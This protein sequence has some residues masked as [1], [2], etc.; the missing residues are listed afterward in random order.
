MENNYVEVPKNWEE[1]IP[2]VITEKD[3]ILREIYSRGQ[4][5]FYDTCSFRR[6]ANLLPQDAECLLKYMKNQD[7]IIVITRC[8]LMELASCS[9]ILNTEY[10]QYIRRIYEMNIN[11]LI[12]YEEEIFHIMEV[13]YATSEQINSFLSWTLRMLK[14][15]V[16]NITKTLNENKSLREQILAGKNRNSRQIYSRFFS[17]VRKNKEEKDNM[18]EEMLAICLHILSYIPGE[19]DGKFCVIT[20]DRGAAGKIDDLFKKTKRQFQG[21]KIIIFSTPKLVQELYTKHI[22]KEEAGLERILATGINGKIKVLGTQI[23]DLKSR[24]ITLSCQE[25]ARLITEQ[26]IHITF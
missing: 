3:S 13:C 18:G 21:K 14:L 25:M 1:I 20:D 11:I 7:G 6:H 22:L 24:E 9:G 8:I 5:F 10:I 19:K 12:I 23:Y 17:E 4:C 26:K 16:S 2:Y 15:P